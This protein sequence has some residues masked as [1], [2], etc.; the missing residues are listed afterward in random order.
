MRAVATLLVAL[1]GCAPAGDGVPWAPG[2]FPPM[3]PHLEATPAQTALGRLLFY[4]PIL[5][6]DREVACATC[7]SELWGLSDGLARSVGVGGEGAVGPGRHGP[8]VTA[9]N[10]PTLWNVAYRR[11]LFWDGR[12]HSLEQQALMPIENA[13]EMGRQVPAL[14]GELQQHEAYR[15]LFD[16]AFGEVSAVAIARALAAFQRTFVS[17]WAP[18]DRYLAGDPGA[19]SPEAIEGMH[20]FHDAGCS[21]CH[22]P[23]LFEREAYFDR[24]VGDDPGRE[25]V[26]GDPADRGAF[27]VPTLRNLRETG[28]YFHD[29]S[30]ASLEEA[31][32]REA[33]GLN[34]AEFAAIATF[35]HKGLMDRTHEPDRPESV[36]S[37]LAL[38][39][40]GF[41]IPR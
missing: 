16:E 24:G 33:D 28:P 8:N 18:Y 14:V 41:R 1:C 39:A 2:A 25:A 10:A 15:A 36:P 21:G 20:L 13:V 11:G 6:A 22:V 9:R 29:G 34:G 19:L 37:G 35:I 40:D 12:A 17:D 38:P 27:R 7:H 5:S 30:V 31:V 3:V 26:T 4:D 32:A 23:P